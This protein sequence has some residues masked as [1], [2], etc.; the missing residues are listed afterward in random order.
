MRRS[1]IPGLLK[2]GEQ[3]ALQHTVAPGT[4]AHCYQ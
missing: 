4:G 2:V 3:G 1:A